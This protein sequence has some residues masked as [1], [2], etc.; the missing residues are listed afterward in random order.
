MDVTRQNTTMISK[1]SPD[2]FML[3]VYIWESILI[4]C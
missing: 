1:A 3:L 4:S 2:I